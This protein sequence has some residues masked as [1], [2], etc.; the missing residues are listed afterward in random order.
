[1]L[2]T[3]PVNPFIAER[4]RELVD[5]LEQQQ[6]NSFRVRAYRQAADT[7]ASYGAGSAH[8]EAERMMRQ[9]REAVRVL[10]RKADP[11]GAGKVGG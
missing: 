10:T 1:M 2:M 9:A 8:H 11:G 6:A 5:L 4:L 3:K 7:V